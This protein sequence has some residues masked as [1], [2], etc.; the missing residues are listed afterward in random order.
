MMEKNI[1]THTNNS[2]LSKL[3]KK[4]SSKIFSGIFTAGISSIFL[5]LYPIIISKLGLFSFGVWATLNILSTLGYIIDFGIILSVVKLISSKDLN[6]KERKTIFSTGLGLLVINILIIS[7]GLFFLKDFFLKILNIQ[8]I[9]MIYTLFDY[10]IILMAIICLQNYLRLTITGI[11]K[12]I[13]SNIL[14]SIC[15]LIRISLIIFNINYLSVEKLILF[16]IFSFSILI[17]LYLGYSLYNRLLTLKF[18]NKKII[19]QIFKYG[20]YIV[21]IR[22]FDFS[23]FPIIKVIISNL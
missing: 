14:F 1:N 7:S 8:N 20:K 6:I 4:K 9:E 18:Y 22:F 11:D 15:E 5:L 12:F 13:V 21:G 23:F 2:L 16:H 19:N 17:L 3:G 10:S